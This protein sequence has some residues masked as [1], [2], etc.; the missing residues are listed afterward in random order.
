MLEV[1][2]KGETASSTSSSAREMSVVISSPA[3]A[4]AGNDGEPASSRAHFVR[5][6]TEGTGI[7]AAVA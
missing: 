3:L 2:G 4:G 5:D 6:R 1:E 7:A